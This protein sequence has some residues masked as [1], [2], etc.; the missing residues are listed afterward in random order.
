MVL[1]KVKIGVNRFTDTKRLIHGTS[2]AIFALNNQF[3]ACP[4]RH[5]EMTP[6]LLILCHQNG[7]FT[8][9]IDSDLDL[10]H[11]IPDLVLGY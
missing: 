11:R 6:Y 3:I 10:L 7:T 1:V 2:M 8:I 5:L 9:C 4:L